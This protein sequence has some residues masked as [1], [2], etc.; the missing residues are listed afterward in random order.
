MR[1]VVLNI[2]R[3]AVVLPCALAASVSIAAAQGP[4]GKEVVVTNTASQPVPVTGQVA[5][6]GVPSVNIGNTVPVTIP[7]VVNVKL[8][9]APFQLSVQ[10]RP[11]G[12]FA[13]NCDSYTVP[14]GA[15]LMIEQVGTRFL[16]G[17]PTTEIVGLRMTTF[18]DGSLA[19]HWI[20]L[21][22]PRT[23]RD[24]FKV[25]AGSQLTKIYADAGSNINFSALVNK[26]TTPLNEGFFIIT[27]S[28]QRISQD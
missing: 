2:A 25:Q 9:D 11:T 15:R 17:D 13:Y 14:A 24:T 26:S 22:Q 4:T 5:I 16:P 27:L 7:G 23:F 6:S 3:T 8:P 18:V 21:P 20:E 28:G 10:C 19:D 1:K 12:F